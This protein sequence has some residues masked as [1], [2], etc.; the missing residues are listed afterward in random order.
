MKKEVVKKCL[1]VL[2]TVCLA[3]SMAACGTAKEGADEKNE[4]S[5]KK[6]E[7]TVSALLQQSRNY[8]GLQKMV[9]KLKEEENISEYEANVFNLTFSLT[10]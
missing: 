10:E 1:A 2:C 8:P 4:K 5:Q 3:G 7:V 6:E 9:E